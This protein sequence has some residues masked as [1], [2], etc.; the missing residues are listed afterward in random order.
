MYFVLLREGAALPPQ[1]VPTTNLCRAQRGTTDK[2]IHRHCCLLKYKHTHKHSHTFLP[3]DHYQLF[4][5]SGPGKVAIFLRCS[6]A[7]ISTK[8]S[9]TVT[10]TINLVMVL[11]VHICVFACAR[12]VWVCMLSPPPCINHCPPSNEDERT[13]SLKH[14]ILPAI[15]P[16]EGMSAGGE[17]KNKIVVMNR[18]KH[19]NIWS[20]G[21]R[22]AQDTTAS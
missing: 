13:D 19:I 2:A 3:I 18:K 15:E 16:S 12:S 22:G 8:V 20:G 1:L 9:Q 6:E 14:L 11:F 5:P 4:F 10:H 21:E 7:G 17:R